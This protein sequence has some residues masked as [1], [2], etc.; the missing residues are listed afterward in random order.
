MCLPNAC[1][2]K[3]FLFKAL[4]KIVTGCFEQ[5]IHL[6]VSVWFLR[7]KIEYGPE[8]IKF[9]VNKNLLFR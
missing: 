2:F 5:F 8:Q 3:Q 7:S 6:R 4:A 1:I 9:Q